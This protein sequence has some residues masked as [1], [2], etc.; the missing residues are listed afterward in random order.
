MALSSCE[1]TEGRAPMALNALNESSDLTHL[2]LSWA[3]R[4]VPVFPVAISK[5]EARVC[6]RQLY[7][8][9]LLAGTNLCAPCERNK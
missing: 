1:P 6:N 7:E 3:A 8:A 4:G 5:N 9:D 2:A